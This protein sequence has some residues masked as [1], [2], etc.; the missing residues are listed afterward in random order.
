MDGLIRKRNAASVGLTTISLRRRPQHRIAIVGQQ[1]VTVF[2]MSTGTTLL[3]LAREARVKC[4]DAPSPSYF[5]WA[6]P[7]LLTPRGC[8]L[9]FLL[10]VGAP[11]PSAYEAT[12]FSSGDSAA[13]HSTQKH[14]SVTYIHS[15]AECITKETQ[16]TGV[17]SFRAKPY[18]PTAK[19]LRGGC[20][21]NRART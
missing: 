10:P 2:D 16:G 7:L 15:Q 3:E 11:S 20:A 13:L 8:T 14:K 12:H 9:S 18:V 21:R 5:P 4:A 1:L 17:A 19:D 6:R